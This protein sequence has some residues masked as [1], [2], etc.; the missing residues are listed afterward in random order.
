MSPWTLPSPPPC[1]P[2]PACGTHRAIPLVI[3]HDRLPTLHP[4]QRWEGHD[5]FPLAQLHVRDAVHLPHADGQL[6]PVRF[7]RKLF[8]GGRE[9]P[10]PDAP[11]G[12]EVH[13]GDGVPLVERFDVVRG[14]VRRVP[15][16]A[17]GI[18]ECGEDL[19]QRLLVALVRHGLRLGVA[20]VKFPPRAPLVQVPP[21][22]VF[23]DVDLVSSQGVPHIWC[24]SR[25]TGTPPALGIGANNTV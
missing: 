25:R 21:A 20:A 14:K 15:L 12:K 3:R 4:A 19:L 17:V 22:D 10:A 13:E 6:P 24:R 16:V 5:A 2:T 8:P 9:A 23:R 11:G 18:R 7:R 1:A